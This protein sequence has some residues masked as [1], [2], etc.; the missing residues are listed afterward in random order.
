MFFLVQRRISFSF[1][2]GVE[3]QYCIYQYI[4]ACSG[5]VRAEG[6]NQEECI[7]YFEQSDQAVEVTLHKIQYSLFVQTHM[8]S[9]YLVS[10]ST[11]L[12]E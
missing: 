3:F 5:S 11:L 1:F 9:T 6:A 4:D 8:Y 7:F 10:N 2:Y 12:Q